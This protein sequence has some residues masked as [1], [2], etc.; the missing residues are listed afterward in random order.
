MDHRQQEMMN[1]VYSLLQTATARDTENHACSHSRRQPSL[2][3]LSAA[4]AAAAT[5]WVYFC[6]SCGRRCPLQQRRQKFYCA[7]RAV[8]T[9]L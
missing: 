4:A 3:S 5:D 2:V 6:L 7:G 1:A 9:R 8:R